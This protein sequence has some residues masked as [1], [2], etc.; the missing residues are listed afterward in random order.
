MKRTRKP[1]PEL[2]AELV[3]LG[4]LNAAGASSKAAIRQRIA[5]IAAERKLDP[6]EIN[7]LMKGRWLPTFDLCQFAKKHRLSFDWL[8]GGD[9]KGRLR[10]AQRCPSLPR[11]DVVDNGGSAA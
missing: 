1:Q 5:L 11:Q 7:S 3:A 6:S 2:P 4:R 10:M 8:L 9:L